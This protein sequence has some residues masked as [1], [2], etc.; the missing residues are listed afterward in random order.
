M[1]L[2]RTHRGD[3]SQ[4]ELLLGTCLFLLLSCRCALLMLANE[5]IE[6]S[7]LAVFTVPAQITVFTQRCTV[8][9]RRRGAKDIFLSLSGSGNKNTANTIAL[10]RGARRVCRDGWMDGRMD[11]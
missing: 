6:E 2:I 10:P 9:T 11:K 5:Q 3:K 8:A 7:T 4:L 1:L